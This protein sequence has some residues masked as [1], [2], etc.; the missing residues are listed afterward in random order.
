MRHKSPAPLPGLSSAPLSGSATL[1]DRMPCPLL[2]VQSCAKRLAVRCWCDSYTTW[3]NHL[4][5]ARDVDTNQ[6]LNI[7]PHH[8][9]PP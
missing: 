2:H 5:I 1:D 3:V 8:Q 4:W 9:V 6:R 7:G